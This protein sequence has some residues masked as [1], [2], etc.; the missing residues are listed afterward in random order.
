M[1]NDDSNSPAGATSVQGASSQVTPPVAN[2]S[3]PIDASPQPITSAAI[4]EAKSAQEIAD[5]KFAEQYRANL[6]AAD[7]FNLVNDPRPIR[8]HFQDEYAGKGGV[9]VVDP[10]TGKRKPA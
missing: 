10:V 9:Y 1:P 5:E 3:K 4:V 7:P 8:K 2:V 6:K